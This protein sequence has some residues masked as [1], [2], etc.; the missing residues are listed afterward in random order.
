MGGIGAMKRSRLRNS[1]WAAALAAFAA[2]ALVVAACGGASTTASNSPSTS[3]NTAVAVSSTP[4]PTPPSEGWYLRIYN[5]D[6]VGKAYV[7]GTLV[8]KVGYLEDSGWVDITDYVKK[9]GGKTA[10]R[11]TM[12]NKGSGY[13]WGFQV[14]TAPDDPDSVV[15]TAEEGLAGSVGANGRDEKSTNRI[16]YDKTVYLKNLSTASPAP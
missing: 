14:A 11:F 15:W 4:S 6:E 8:K 13:T 1:I 16:V 2:A 12:Y 5:V 9:T 10:I 7:N 3:P